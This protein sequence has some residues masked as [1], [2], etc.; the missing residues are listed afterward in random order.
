MAKAV[1]A[2]EVPAEK[3]AAPAVKI[4]FFAEPGGAAVI[5]ILLAAAGLGLTALV[6][7]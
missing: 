3:E 5:G 7:F 4:D 1:S 6:F 2:P